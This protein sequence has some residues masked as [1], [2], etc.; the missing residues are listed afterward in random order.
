MTAV[1]ATTNNLGAPADALTIRAGLP[2]VG[3]AGR[4]HTDAPGVGGT[5][6]QAWGSRPAL[7]P[8]A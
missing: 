2:G 7:G 8:D 1:P 3:V 4:A 6:L 5:I